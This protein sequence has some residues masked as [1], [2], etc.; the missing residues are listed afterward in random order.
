MEP[1]RLE[2]VIATKTSGAIADAIVLIAASV[3]STVMGFQKAVEAK[4]REPC[5]QYKSIRL[6]I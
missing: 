3:L 4:N 5:C 6:R 2:A 1:T